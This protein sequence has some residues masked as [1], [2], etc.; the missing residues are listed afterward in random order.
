MLRVERESDEVKEAIIDLRAQGFS[1][2]A[3]AGE[4][5]V[6]FGCDLTDSDISNYFMKNQNK[7]I[8]VLN[9]SEKFQERLAEQY[10]NSVEKVNTLANEMWKFFYDV[11]K[12]PELTNRV[13]DCPH[14]KKQFS[15][16]IKQ[17]SDFIKIADHLLKQIQHVD[18]VLGKLQNKNLS[19]NYNVVDINQKIV[20]IMPQILERLERQDI[21]KIKKKSVLKGN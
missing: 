5:N 10:F 19:I 18:A 7:V 2:E 17:Y 4:V 3:I 12:D 21:I 1:N 13:V 6:K 11:K 14:C 9:K 16:K 8:E 15:V 20:K